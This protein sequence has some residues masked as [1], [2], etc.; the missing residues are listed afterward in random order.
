MLPK[1]GEFHFL[2]EI[3]SGAVDE[4]ST[5][6]TFG[7]LTN[8]DARIS[9]AALSVHHNSND[10]RLQ[11][12]TSLVEPFEARIGTEYMALG[13]MESTT[14]NVPVIQARLLIDADGV[15][16]PLLEHAVQEQRKYFQQRDRSALETKRTG[17]RDV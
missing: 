14:G 2:W 16:L 3:C 1:P 13:E 10:Y 6:R 5:V 12:L 4:G 9:E 7:R 11:I 15:D 8:Y 17:R